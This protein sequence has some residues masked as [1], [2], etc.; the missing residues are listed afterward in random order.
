M[1]GPGGQGMSPS[2]PCYLPTLSLHLHPGTWSLRGLPG[3]QVK[4]LPASDHPLLIYG[5]HTTMIWLLDKQE[6]VRNSNQKTYSLSGLVSKENCKVKKSGP[7]TMPSSTPFHLFP[8]Y[9]TSL[10]GL[11]LPPTPV[12]SAKDKVTLKQKSYHTTSLS[13]FRAESKLPRLA[14]QGRSLLSFWGPHLSSSQPLD[15]FLA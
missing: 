4:Q 13:A 2:P 5:H 1:V 14:S 6:E 10:Q 15:L 3:T 9:C 11:S 8:S 7:V 12:Y